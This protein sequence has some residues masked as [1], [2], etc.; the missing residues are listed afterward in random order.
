MLNFFHASQYV[1]TV[2]YHDRNN[3]PASIACLIVYVDWVAHR[4]ELKTTTMRVR[5]RRESHLLES[6]TAEQAMRITKGFRQF[7]VI[8]SLGDDQLYRLLGSLDGRGELSGL[9]LKL[10]R[11]ESS[12]RK[13]ERRVQFVEMPLNT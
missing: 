4:M 3:I 9:A 7:E 1:H 2:L 6:C 5:T 13:D 12:M 10:G 8:V 11:L